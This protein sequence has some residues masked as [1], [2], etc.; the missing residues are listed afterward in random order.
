MD[1]C[2][3][4]AWF[5]LYSVLGW[6]YECAYCAI[7]TKRWDNRGFL[8]GPVCP[9]YGFGMSALVIAA[10]ALAAS[11]AGSASVPWWQ[12]FLCATAGS[13]VLEYTT[14]YVL[15][16]CF[17]ARWWDYSNIP[18][19][20]NGRIC[21]PFALCFGAVGTLL[22]YFVCPLIGGATVTLPLTAW[23]VLALL[24]V[25]LMSADLAL[26]LSALT[27]LDK[28]VQQD[29]SNFDAVMETA[30]DDIAAGRKPLEVDREIAREHATEELESAAH[31]AAREMSLVQRRTLKSIKYYSEEH[32]EARAAKLREAVAKVERERKARKRSK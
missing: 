3:Y 13:A 24:T 27:N 5:G 8:F 2:S 22:Y 6:V 11:G 28:R 7:R 31:R 23:E 16:K 25:G 20:L 15:E 30:V 10:Q 21:L 17:H 26:T 32:R 18:L 12:V 1:I 14:S 9:I 4:V 29:K 19:N